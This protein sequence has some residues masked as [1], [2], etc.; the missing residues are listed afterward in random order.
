MK[1]IVLMYDMTEAILIQ[2]LDYLNSTSTNDASVRARKL[3]KGGN[4]VVSG[5]YRAMS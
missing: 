5:D 1:N 4:R 2:V 3:A